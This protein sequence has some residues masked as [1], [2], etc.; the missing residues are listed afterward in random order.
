[1]PAGQPVRRPG[2]AA[3]ATAANAATI[4]HPR[5]STTHLT[6]ADRRG[7]VV[8]Y[9]FTIEST[10]GNGIVVP[11]Y[12]FLLNNELTDFNYDSTDAP[13]PRRRAASARAARWRRRS[14]RSAASRT[15]RSARRAARRSPAPCCR[16]SSTGSTCASRCPNAIALPRAVE[17]NTAT[18]QAEQSFINSPEGR[19]LAGAARH[20][21]APPAAPGE[22]G[23]A[24]AIEFRAAAGSSRRPSRS[25]AAPARPQ[26]S[27]RA[28]SRRLGRLGP[29][30]GLGRGAVPRL[31]SSALWVAVGGGAGAAGCR[32]RSMGGRDRKQSP[33][34]VAGCRWGGGGRARFQRSLRLRRVRAQGARVTTS[35]R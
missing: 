33:V 9:T 5:Q 35:V 13:E 11:G 23:A 10:G 27:G 32:A 1:M 12:G 30:V 15:W 25:G 17:R 4:S 8:S 20:R 6:V 19:D 28:E 7:N 18:T 26:W 21:F 29:G 34:V 14:S 16:R 22:I 31:G 3:P 24:T 2:R